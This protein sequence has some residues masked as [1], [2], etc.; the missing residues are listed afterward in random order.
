[1]LAT[2]PETA[3]TSMDSEMSNF[4][5]L[6]LLVKEI[7]DGKCARWTIKIKISC[8]QLYC[9]FSKD[10]YSDNKELSLATNQLEK[11]LDDIIGQE[12]RK[13]I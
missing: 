1:M 6:L 3:D 12:E 7:I 4:K 8:A 9:F 13:R 5:N 10:S 2:L 11:V